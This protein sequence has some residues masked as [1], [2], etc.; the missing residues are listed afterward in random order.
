M[1]LA[2]EIADVLVELDT[3]LELAAEFT[4]DQW[5]L[6]GLIADA[7][8]PKGQHSSQRVGW[9]LLPGKITRQAVL[10]ILQEKEMVA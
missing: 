2:T 7:R 3:P 8:R 9:S 4:E 10:S 1:S 6:A 5:K